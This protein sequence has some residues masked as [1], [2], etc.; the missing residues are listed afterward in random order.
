MLKNEGDMLSRVVVCTPKDEY[1]RVSN[2]EIHSITQLADRN[3][4][5]KQHDELKS[6]LAGF[7]C[8]VIDSPELPNHP[9]SVFTRD[10]ALCTPRGYVKLRMGLRTRRGEEVWMSQVLDSL[11]ESCAGNIREPGTVE[12]GDIILAGLVAFIG[13]SQ[14]TNEDGVKQISALLSAMNYE[15]RSITV[16]PPYLHIGGAMSVIGLECVL[17]CRGVFPDGFF[18]GF[19]KIEVSSDTFVSGNVIC[20]GNNEVVADVANVEAVKELERAG[21]IVHAVDLSEFVKGRGGPN[22]LIMP[23]ERKNGESVIVRQF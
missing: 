18:D 5:Q 16:P 8:E 12:G 4:A 19:H 14:R 6:I 10:T 11:G 21:F 3:R 17:C 13:R 23:V 1:F 15:V 9:N 20:L 22:C 7:G 2:F